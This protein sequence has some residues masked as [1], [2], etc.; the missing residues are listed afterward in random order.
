MRITCLQENLK[1]NLLILERISSKNQELPILGNVLLKTEDGFLKAFSTDLEIGVEIAIPCKIEKKG[2]VVVPIKLISGFIS[3]LP[4]TKLTLEEK[5]NKVI[6]ETEGVTTSI[7]TASKNE[8]P[9]IPKIKEESVITIQGEVL[10][11]GITQVMNSVA[12]SY[13]IPEIA[14]VLFVCGKD[15]LKIV[16]TD[17]FRLSEKTIFKNKTYAVKEER[18]FILPAK[19]ASELSKIISS[20]DEMVEI[21]LTQNQVM[22]TVKNTTIVSRLV[23]GEY[24][25]YERIIPK[26]SKTKIA[27][28]KT[29]FVSKL[30]LASLF[31]SKIN[32]VKITTD[33]HKKEIIVRSADQ[34]KGDFSATI[35][36][37]VSG[38]DTEVLFNY[39][40]L[41]DGLS[42][43]NEEDVVF[44]LNG[45]ASPAILRSKNDAYQYVAMPIKM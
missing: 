45:A 42:N 24:P 11:N 6:I 21:Y 8:F 23:A 32:D 15:V 38:E 14:G 34:S 7:P 4:N 3:N 31:S 33:A 30:K 44:E 16:A 9:L 13:S 41:L 12:L 39:R 37:D 20:E 17:S 29:E 1:N 43:I 25:N 36:A 40:Y 5:N 10:R 26:T 27:L 19:T 22:F 35:H 18:S 2:E 28:N